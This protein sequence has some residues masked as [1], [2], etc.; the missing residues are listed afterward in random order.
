MNASPRAVR[1]V[2]RRGGL[3]WQALGAFLLLAAVAIALAGCG[4]TSGSSSLRWTD[5]D[6]VWMPG[7]RSIV[8]TSNRQAKPA[9]WSQDGG[10]WRLYRMRLQ[11]DGAPQ[12]PRPL[13]SPGGHG[14]VDE[15]PAPSRNGE[16][17]AFVRNC[18]G[19]QTE[20]LMV[21]SSDGGPAKTL[22]TNVDGYVLLG[23]A[24]LAWSP[25]GRLIAFVRDRNP[26]SDFSN[27]DLWV[28]DPIHGRLH[29]VAKGTGDQ[30]YGSSIGGYAWSPRGQTIA[31]GCEGGSVCVADIHSRTIRRLHRFSSQDDVPSVA[32][33]SNGNELAFVDGSGGSYNPDYYA[34]VMNT[35]GT[36]LHR[37]CRY[38][39]GNADVVQWLPRHP[40]ELVLTTDAASVYLIGIAGRRPHELPFEA[41]IVAPSPN[42]KRLLFVRR[43]FDSQG[44][45]YRSAVS[46][47]G[48]NAANTQKLTQ[49]R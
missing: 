15:Y 7:G 26:N 6:A 48:L 19:E 44:N 16:K 25:D 45:Y 46:L 33:S 22:A 31:F 5:D 47:A 11:P 39:D 2:Q 27:T 4:G 1:F 35:N 21:V 32:W 10:S 49:N 8:F 36:H 12:Q 3:G 28:A 30:G 40:Q 37:V 38:C 23:G 9:Q 43:V 13:T 24:P 14:C 41:D 17:V 29:R 18:S 34:W 42:G 20:H